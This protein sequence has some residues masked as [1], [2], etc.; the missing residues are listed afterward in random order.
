MT[1]GASSRLAA[2]LQEEI[3]GLRR[4]LARAGGPLEGLVGTS[5]AMQ[6][7]F[8]RIFASAS[9]NGPI[10]VTGERGAGRSATA[11]AIHALSRRR[12]LPIATLKVEPGVASPSPSELARR[13]AEAP[14]ATIVLE[15]FH[16]GPPGYQAEVR[17]FADSHPSVQFLFVS[18]RDSIGTLGAALV[19]VPPLRTRKEDIPQLAEYF[20]EQIETRTPAGVSGIDPRALEAMR[21]HDWPGNLRELRNVIAKA[22]ELTGGAWIGLTTIQSVLGGES[23]LPRSAGRAGAAEDVVPVR[24]GD[25]MAEVE[26]RVLQRTLRFAQGNKKK[27]AEML[28]LSLKTI[29]NKVKEYG[30][31][32]E[33]SRRLQKAPQSDSETLRSETR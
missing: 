20:L 3:G 13:A 9:E 27:A 14:G 23:A 16:L 22:H 4:A 17:R 7:L 25:S 10:V 28:K 11:G 18:T 31:E 5:G 26:R 12:R 1:T 33:F 6:E 29:Y 19:A 30:L 21:A 8:E 15:D 24:V 2:E 32:R